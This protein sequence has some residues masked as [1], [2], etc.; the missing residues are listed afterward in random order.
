MALSVNNFKPGIDTSILKEV[1]AEILKRA[2]EKN[3]QYNTGSVNNVFKS[4]DLG[5]DLY[6]G[7]VDNNTARQIAMTNSGLNVQLN[8]NV[9]ASIN[10]LNAQAA[11]N[12]HKNVEGKMTVAVNETVENE[13]ATQAPSQFNSIV[14]LAAGKDKNSSNPKYNGEL[15]GFV[16]EE[17]NEEIENIFS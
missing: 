12:V 6:R 14:S 15:L 16:K 17:K 9:L 1:S 8:Q 4:A 7:S 11:K 2:A 10:F 13:K 3:S 5:V